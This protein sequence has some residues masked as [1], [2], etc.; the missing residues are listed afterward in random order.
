[1][2]HTSANSCR[3]WLPKAFTLVEVVASLLLLGTLLVG[4]LSAHRQHTRQIRSAELRLE[5]IAAADQLLKS[6][7]T[8]GTWGSVKSSG[9][10]KDHE[11]FVWQ[12]TVR[13]SPDL[14]GLPAAVGRLNVFSVD[15][16]QE[17]PLVSVELLADNVFN[18][19]EESGR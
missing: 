8:E 16:D 12:W 1:M 5:A 9:R 19:P 7:Q 11:K 15:G 18:G 2:R 6:W 4:L 3:P 13:T 10:F 17:E 14:R